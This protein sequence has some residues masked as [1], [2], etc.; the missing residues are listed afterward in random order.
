M[1]IT[2]TA[3]NQLVKNNIIVEV[4]SWILRTARCLHKTRCTFW[5]SP[6]WRCVLPLLCQPA[7]SQVSLLK[8]TTIKSK[9]NQKHTY[10]ASYVASESEAH[11][12]GVSRGRGATGSVDPP[13][14]QVRSPH[15]D[16]DPPLFVRISWC[17]NAAD[18]TF[19]LS[20]KWICDR[21]CR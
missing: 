2:S 6:D 1:K 7:A 20:D 12:W 10:I 3:V 16:V 15:M 19:K 14:F 8:F 21:K 4:L 17:M 13:L 9:S 5:L 11:K 18:N